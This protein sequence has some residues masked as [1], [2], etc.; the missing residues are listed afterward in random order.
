MAKFGE[1]HAAA[2]ARL[3]LAEL[4]NAA[5]PSK[6]SVADKDMGLY[7]SATQGEIAQ[8][9]KGPGDGP[10]QESMADLKA[11]AQEKV[12]ESPAHE[13]MADL[14]AAAQEKAQEAAKEV[15]GP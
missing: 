2:M 13:S 6:E 4:R 9:R 3:G 12:Q 11:A 8:A 7:G 1:G 10:E 15:S 14:K 5:N